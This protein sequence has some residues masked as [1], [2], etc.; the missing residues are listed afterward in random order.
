VKDLTGFLEDSTIRNKFIIN[1][2]GCQSR[3]IQLE[4]P[5][6]SKPIMAPLKIK[7]PCL[8]TGLL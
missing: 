3:K 1:C 5:S 7:K 4:N 6:K 8:S 2:Q